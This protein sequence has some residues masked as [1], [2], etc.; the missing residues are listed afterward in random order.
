MMN[1]IKAGMDVISTHL[2]VLLLP[3][4]LDAV[5]WFG[6]RLSV[7]N[8]LTKFFDQVVAFNLQNN[9]PITEL[10]QNRD[11]FI[12]N[13]SHF[14]LFSL[15][16]TFPV[17]VTS[18]ISGSLTIENPLG[19]QSVI[20]VSSILSLFGWLILLVLSGWLMGGLYFT[21]VARILGTRQTVGSFIQSVLQTFLFCFIFSA[22]A[23][24]IGLPAM[25]LLGTLGLI[26]QTVLQIALFILALASAWIIVPLFFSPLGIYMG[27]NNAFRSIFKS[28]RMARFTLPT[29]SMFVL[30][31]F[32][33]SQGMNYLWSVPPEN[34]WMRL[35]G[36]AGHA[37]VTTALLAASFIY[38]RDLNNWLEIVFE[39]MKTGTATP[40][41]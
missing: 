3:L 4:A 9:I 11:D 41:A 38:Y 5:L 32:I 25:L 26:S 22:V 10:A 15:L 1:A 29:S 14:N 40:Q 2:S 35:V 12:E 31:V 30:A 37:F 23:F 21:W 8:L 39:R 18:L 28:F 20:E 33:I 13:L 36:I 16:R 24:M 19:A 17:G 27:G 34:S 6:P 7:K